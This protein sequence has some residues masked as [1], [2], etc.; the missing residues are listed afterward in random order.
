MLRWAGLERSVIALV[1]SACAGMLGYAGLRGVGM[2]AV[3]AVTA[4]LVIGLPAACWL[5]LRLPAEL[6][7]MRRTK[8]PLALIWS[9]VALY[10]L[11]Q[12]G[13]LT[14]FMVDPDSSQNSMDPGDPW[15]VHHCCLTAYT[16]GARF[17]S[18]GRPNVYSEELYANRRVDSFSVDLYHYPPTFLLLPMAVH[19]V[20]DEGFRAER[21]VWFSASGLTLMLAMGLIA[22]RVERKGRLRLIGMAPLIWCSMPVLVGLQMSNVQILVFA[23][24]AL[25]LV[26]FS[27]RT[28]AGAVA[29]AAT[30]VAKIFPGMI[31]IYLISRRKWREVVWTLGAGI[32]MTIL[33]WIVVGPASFESFFSYQLPRLSSGEA[34]ARPFAREFAVA[35][36]MAPFGIPLKLAALGVPGMTLGVGRIV[37]MIYLAC[38]IGLAVWAGRRQPRSGTEAASVWLALVSLGTLASPFAPGQYVL[39]SLVWLVCLDHER[40]RPLFA[41]IVW[42]LVS[43]PFLVSREAPVLIQVLTSLPSQVLAL[44]VPAWVLWKSGSAREG[45]VM[46]AEVSPLALR[47]A[48]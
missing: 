40:F 45:E 47:R 15:L 44:G 19:V 20:A 27:G 34:F 11:V 5:A 23:T 30:M 22:F 37:S 6:D 7:G 32:A 3:V 16:E 35:R 28:P 48:G 17:A 41:V 1:V 26:L 8:I 14:T 18:E 13:C 36:N 43:A 46:Q 25:S 21:A 39:V 29:L 24:A 42:L 31:F 33:A 9:L 12:T 2:S 38:I 10:A 4:V